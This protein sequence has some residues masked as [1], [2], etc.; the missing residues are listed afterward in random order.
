ME[1]EQVLHMNNVRLTWLGHSCFEI[2]SETKLLIDPFLDNNPVATVSSK[3]V[4]PDY[5]AVTHG[6]NDH[7][8]DTEKIALRTGCTVACIHELSNYLKSKGIAT[9][10]MNIGGTIHLGD[11]SLT[12]TPAAH[13]SSII[14]GDK[15]HNGGNAAG[16]IIH[17]PGTCIYHAGDTGLFGDMKMI[18]DIYRPDVAILPIGGR[19]TMDPIDAAIAVSM[20][21]PKYAIPMHYNTFEQIAQD[22]DFFA[23]KV[24][25]IT[26]VVIP[27]VNGYIDL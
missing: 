11:L 12:M 3:D 10:G 21:R 22:P 9:Q 16:F 13:S 14:E 27:E 26:E 15:V 24:K 1:E 18:G 20:L 19:Y 23:S 5:I 17:A 7:L 4:E 2:N 8:G 25:D 6:H